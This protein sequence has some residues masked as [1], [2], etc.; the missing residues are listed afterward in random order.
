M[1]AMPAKKKNA[2]DAEQKEHDDKPLENVEGPTGDEGPKKKKQKTSK[3]GDS[4]KETVDHIPVARIKRIVK[5]DPEAGKI[6]Q[7]AAVAVGAATELFLEYFC[8]CALRPLLKSNRKTLNYS[9][10]AQTVANQEVFEFLSDA[11]PHQIVHR[12]KKPEVVA[13]EKKGSGEE[14]AATE[15]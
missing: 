11:I 8:K 4:G 6:G 13:N 5:Q 2:A 7:E 1:Y 3:G 15:A 9:D 10:C 12:P 14:T